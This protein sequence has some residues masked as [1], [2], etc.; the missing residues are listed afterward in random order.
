MKTADLH[1]SPFQKLLGLEL[2]SAG[3]GGVT[4]RMPPNPHLLRVDG[5]AQLHG[6]VLTALID[7]AGSYAVEVAVGGDAPTVDLRID[8][9]K[10]AEGEL[11]A[12]ARVQKRGRK[13]C[14]ADIEVRDGRQKV[15]AIGRGLFANTKS[16]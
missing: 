10:P 3:D 4:I 8:Y 9:L 1:I 15:V 6:G 2:V 16:E 12:T 5:S 7:I 11:V 14:V 13:L